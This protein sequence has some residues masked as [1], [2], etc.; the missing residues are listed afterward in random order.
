[1]QTHHSD[2]PDVASPRR[3]M[4]VC[5]TFGCLVAAVVGAQWLSRE[6]F[7]ASTAQVLG[8]T[9][10]FGVFGSL[11]GSFAADAIIGSRPHRSPARH[12]A[13]TSAEPMG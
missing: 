7:D 9:A 3:I 1:M 11:L 12:G 4:V 8:A 13:P 2:W 5:C 10:A 6:A